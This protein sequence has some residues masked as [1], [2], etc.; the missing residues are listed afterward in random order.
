MA[1]LKWYVVRAVSGQEKKVKAYLETEVQRQNLTEFVSSVQIPTERV[2]EVKNGVKKT[3]DKILYAGYVL[4]EAD[5]NNGEAFHTITSVPG[6]IGFLSTAEE[7]S[8]EIQTASATSKTGK[9]K[10]KIKFKRPI[11]LRESEVT[12]ILGQMDQAAQTEEKIETPFVRGEII[13]VMDG[14][15]TGFTGTI[16]EIFEE[17]KRLSVTVKIFGRSTPVELNYIQVEKQ[18]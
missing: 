5:L 3:R 15:F 2:F 6:V 17:R 4:V 10:V 12:K 13:K 7:K 14:P 8:V 18:S 9:E 11:P 16:E 1:E